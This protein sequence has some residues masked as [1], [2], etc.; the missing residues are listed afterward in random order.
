MGYIGDGAHG[1]WGI[2]AME[3]Q[4]AIGYRQ[5]RVHWVWVDGQWGTWVMGVQGV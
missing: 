2:L 5:C 1:Q 3:T 4:R